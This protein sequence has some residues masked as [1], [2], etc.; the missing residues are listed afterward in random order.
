M[1]ETF[2]SFFVMQLHN[3]LQRLTLASLIFKGKVRDF[4]SGASSL[5]T[6]GSRLTLNCQTNLKTN[7]LAYFVVQLVT[8]IKSF[9]KLT[10]NEISMVLFCKVG[11]MVSVIEKKQ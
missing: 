5:L 9:V 3:K 6:V 11:I 4:A 1:F 8:K 2:F 7:T 10:P